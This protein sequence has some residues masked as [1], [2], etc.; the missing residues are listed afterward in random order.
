[1]RVLSIVGA[2]PN[3]IKVAPIHAVFQKYRDVE[4]RIVHTG[5]HYDTQMSGIFFDQLDLPRPDYFLG[6]NN[7]THTQQTASIML[8]FEKVI[9]VEKP[10]VVLVVGDVNSTLACALV[11]AKEQ[12]PVVH[13]EAGL[14]SGDRRMPEEINRIITDSISDLL[15]VTE[16]AAVENLIKENIPVGKI[17][18]TGNVLIDSLALYRE[19]AS[20]V[21]IPEQLNLKTRAY[22]LMTMHRP[23]NVDNE[24]S[25]RQIIEIIKCI[26]G[27]ITVVFPIHPRT[28]K[29]I[30]VFGLKDEVEGIKGLQILKPQG[31]LEFL[32]LMDKAALVITD[33]GGV[34]EETTFLDVPCIT[35]RES[36]ERPVTVEVGTNYLLNTLDRTVVWHAVESI[37]RGSPK[38]SKIPYLWDG[39][40][41]ERIVTILRE[42]YI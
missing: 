31:Y 30:S 27:D 9:Y 16:Q 29:N 36:T 38:K 15:F 39:K 2:R 19:K 12:I 17:H 4:S 10:D 40:A 37:L 3:F 28:F 23:A 20:E 14:R 6:I 11:A 24:K 35:L 7:G 1:L 18:F 25:L 5:Q 26:A 21:K 41:A 32:N 8:E 13:I 42:K 33:S 22:V 34:Q